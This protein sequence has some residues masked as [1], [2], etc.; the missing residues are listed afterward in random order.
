MGSRDQPFA[1]YCVVSMTHSADLGVQVGKTGH[2]ALQQLS[3]GLCTI[4]RDAVHLVTWTGEGSDCRLDIVPVFR[5]GV[6]IDDCLAAVAKAGDVVDSCH[7]GASWM[8]R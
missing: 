1:E 2:E 4:A 5:L 8:P 6:L 3:H 7:Y